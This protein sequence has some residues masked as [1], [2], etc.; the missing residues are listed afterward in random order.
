MSET[1]II[2]LCRRSGCNVEVE[3]REDEEGKFYAKHSN[4]SGDRC[5]GSY[6]PVPA[7]T[8]TKELK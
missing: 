8:E 5:K 2:A 1:I 4:I 6:R 7:G 3:V